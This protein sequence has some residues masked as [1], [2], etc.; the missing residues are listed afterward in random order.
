VPLHEEIGNA[1]HSDHME[2]LC[3]EMPREHCLHLVDWAALIFRLRSRHSIPPEDCAAPPQLSGN[4]QSWQAPVFTRDLSGAV[5]KP[6][7]GW[8]CCHVRFWHKADIQLPPA[9]VRFRG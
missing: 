4:R 5:G 8:A 6:E 3:D 9:N 1:K 7:I 2:T